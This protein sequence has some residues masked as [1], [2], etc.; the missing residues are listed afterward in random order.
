M[1]LHVTDPA[2]PFGPKVEKEYGIIYP[3]KEGAAAA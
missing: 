3:L 1:A 2:V